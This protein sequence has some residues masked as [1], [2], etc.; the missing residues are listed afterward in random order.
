MTAKVGLKAI[1]VVT[2]TAEVEAVLKGNHAMMLTGTKYLLSGVKIMG[3]GISTTKNRAQISNKKLIMVKESLSSI[4]VVTTTAEV[5]A[6]LKV[7]H[8][9][10]LTAMILLLSGL[11]V[12]RTIWKDSRTNQDR[13]Q[14][15]ISSTRPIKEVRA[16]VVHTKT[17]E[18]KEEATTAVRVGAVM[19]GIKTT[20]NMRRTIS[21]NLTRDRCIKDIKTRQSR[22]QE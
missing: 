15:T 2:K 20:I 21:R 6:V 1:E 18:A 7:K 14:L 17:T 5:E 4:T 8:D 11:I 10:I 3:N 9:R 22:N 19:K 12:V 16:I 13:V